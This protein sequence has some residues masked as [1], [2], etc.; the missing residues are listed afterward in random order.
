M[1]ATNTA[2]DIH[3]TEVAKQV[4]KK[5]PGVVMSIYSAITNELLGNEVEY[6][7]NTKV[8]ELDE[9]IFN[10]LMEIDRKAGR[11]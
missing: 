9:Y 5:F 4:E 3:Y 7:S 8:I 11:L 6:N 2:K 1:N 10:N